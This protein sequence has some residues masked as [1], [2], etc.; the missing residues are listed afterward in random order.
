MEREPFNPSEFPS[1]NSMRID[2]GWSQRGSATRIPV[3]SM[4]IHQS[5]DVMTNIDLVTDD[6]RMVSTQPSD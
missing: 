1:Q 6:H 3:R 4:N 2:S 5:D